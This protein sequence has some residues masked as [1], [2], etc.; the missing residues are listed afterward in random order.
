MRA[1]ADELFEEAISE[2]FEQALTDGVVAPTSLL[3]GKR[4]G[5]GKELIIPLKEGVWIWSYDL[6]LNEDTCILSGAQTA[7]HDYVC[8]YFCLSG[9]VNYTLQ[10]RDIHLKAGNSAVLVGSRRDICLKQE[11]KKDRRCRIVGVCFDQDSFNAMTGRKIGEI[12]QLSNPA[13]SAGKHQAPLAMSSVAEQLLLT[14]P[15]GVDRKLFLEAKVME[16]VAYKLGI[17]DG[18]QTKKGKPEPESPSLVEKI[19]H[20]A[21]ILE[22]RMLN[23]PGIFDLSRKVGLNHI[24]LTQGF[25]EIVG[26]TPFKYLS[27]IRLQKAAKLIASGEQNITEAAFSV[28]YSSLSHFSKIFR[29]EF[30]VNPKAYSRLRSSSHKTGR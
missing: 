21:E 17:L 11:I 10:N 23:P 4:F 16:F 20:A 18:Y 26:Q 28:G 2:L 1:L 19:Y 8:I 25:K 9:G 27:K 7:F 24:T 6:T 3:L 29:S 15:D 30:G 14:D 13:L 22:R 12:Y 5:K